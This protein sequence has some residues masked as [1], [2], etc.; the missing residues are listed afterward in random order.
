MI[1]KY[2]PPVIL[3]QLITSVYEENSGVV[4]PSLEGQISKLARSLASNEKIHPL[5]VRS[6]RTGRKI[7]ALGIPDA[8]ILLQEYEKTAREGPLQ[9]ASLIER[10][11]DL[12]KNPPGLLPIAPTTTYRE[13]ENILI[14]ACRSP[15]PNSLLFTLK[16]FG[17]DSVANKPARNEQVQLSMIQAFSTLVKYYENIMKSTN[18]LTKR[19]QGTEFVEV[20][21]RLIDE[22]AERI[23]L[24]PLESDV[25]QHY[26]SA[27]DSIT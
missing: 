6:E 27:P 12:V 22:L 14:Q 11:T 15:V 13:I 16:K 18:G 2:I 17:Q 23:A 21:I 24:T 26:E 3:P 9:V 4:Q 19:W 1:E 7:T 20:L 25:K 8:I 10:Y 5:F